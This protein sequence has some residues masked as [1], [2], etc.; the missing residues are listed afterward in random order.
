MIASSLRG[1]VRCH[2]ILPGLTSKTNH[3]IRSFKSNAWP[4]TDLAQTVGSFWPRVFLNLRL[5]QPWLSPSHNYRTGQGLPDNL[6]S[7][8]PSRVSSARVLC[9]RVCIVPFFTI[10]RPHG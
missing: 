9:L 2:C 5:I 6:G 8:L 4:D 10:L 3:R 1:R 7:F